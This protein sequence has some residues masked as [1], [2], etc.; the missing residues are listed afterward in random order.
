M[1]L[2]PTMF[3]GIFFGVT[4]FGRASVWE[5]VANYSESC[6]TLKYLLFWI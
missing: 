2:N 5:K 4:A 3:P 6:Q 1:K